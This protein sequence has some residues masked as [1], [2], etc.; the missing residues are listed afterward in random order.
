MQALVDGAQ[1]RGVTLVATL[2]QVD[3]ALSHFPRIVGLRQGRVM[4]DLPTA[5]VTR[6]RLEQLYA[7]HEDELDAAALVP[8]LGPDATA[9]PLAASHCR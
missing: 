9:A 3:M 8:A 4:F 7:Q 1:E 6:G 5:Q 2:H